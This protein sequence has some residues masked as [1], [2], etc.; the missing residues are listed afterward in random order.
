MFNG[1]SQDALD[2]LLGIR[3]NNNK[4]WF[5][6]HKKIYTEKVQA[7]LKDLCEEIAEPYN[8][9]GM[10]HKT[11]RIYRDAGFPP[12]LH[13]RDAMWFVIRHEALYWN[14]T[15]CLYFEISPEG[16]EFGFGIP[17]PEASVMERFRAQL[18]EDP[19]KFRAIAESVRKA[20]ITISGEQYKRKKPCP[21]AE[22]E[23]YWQF[24]SMTA[25]VKVTDTEE[26]FS[27]RLAEHTAEVFNAVQPLY[28]I[29]RE[30]VEINTLAKAIEKEAVLVPEKET[31][32]APDVEFMW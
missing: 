1:F 25:A 20:G 24:R 10:M 9:E 27:R 2:F 11:C 6:A 22:A 7:P 18:A 16:A 15:P 4:E 31:V 26:L 13:Y 32:K 30:L 3:I 21:V 29:F 23:E 8:G 14:R 12:Y 19:A 28:D 17:K 5:E